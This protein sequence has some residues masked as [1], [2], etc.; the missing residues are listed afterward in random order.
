MENNISTGGALVLLPFGTNY[1]VFSISILAEIN[2]YSPFGPYTLLIAESI[3]IRVYSFG[4]R[5][6]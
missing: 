6:F 5:S 4:V 1:L 2:G 3:S